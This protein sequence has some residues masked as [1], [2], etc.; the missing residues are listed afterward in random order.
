MMIEEKTIFSVAYSLFF[1]VLMVKVIG[2]LVIWTVRSWR[3]KWN[4]PDEDA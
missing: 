2:D 3:H 1:V 4:E